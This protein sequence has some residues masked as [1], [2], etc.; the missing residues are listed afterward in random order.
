[1]ERQRRAAQEAQAAAAAAALHAALA[2][3][4]HRGPPVRELP[5]AP[6]AWARP[7][8]KAMQAALYLLHHR[9]R[10]AARTKKVRALAWPHCS[11]CRWLSC[12]PPAPSLRQ[13]PRAQPPPN[14]H[15]Q[16]LQHVYP[17]LEPAQAREFKAAM[18]GWV[19]ELAAGSA[20]SPDAAKYFPSAYQGSAAHRSVLLLLDLR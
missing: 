11:S 9:I 2:A 8:V 13:H 6:A 5:A 12:L 17:V 18:Q 20:I 19:G 4:Q 10:G 1:M 7:S 14:H 16:E 3:L 15:K